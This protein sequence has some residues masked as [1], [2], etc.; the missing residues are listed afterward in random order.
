[1]KDGDYYESGEIGSKAHYLYDQRHF[2]IG[3]ASKAHGEY[4][5]YY[6]TGEIRSKRNYLDGDKHGECIDYYESGE[7]G[8]KLYYI[9][10]DEVSESEFLCY[11]RDIKLES[12]L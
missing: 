5:S 1:M 10:H 6:Q 7:I 2:S 11:I 8:S 9:N 3:I 4:I 12:I